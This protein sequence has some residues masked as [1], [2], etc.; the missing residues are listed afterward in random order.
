MDKCRSIC[1]YI[2]SFGMLREKN[3]NEK[4]KGKNGKGKFRSLIGRLKNI[5]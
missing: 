1:S 3:V 5:Q 2:E 4:C